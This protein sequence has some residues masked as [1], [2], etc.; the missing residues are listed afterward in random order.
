MSRLTVG[1][2]DGPEG[3]FRVGDNGLSGRVLGE[4]DLVQEVKSFDCWKEAASFFDPGA[5][6]ELEWVSGCWCW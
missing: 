5:D 4:G 3:P 1:I 6:Q 2:R